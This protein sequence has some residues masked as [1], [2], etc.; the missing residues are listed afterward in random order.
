MTTFPVSHLHSCLGEPYF[1]SQLLPGEDVWVVSLVKDCLQLLEL[2]EGECRP[3][4]PLLPPQE[5]LVVHVR[6]VAEGGVCKQVRS[7]LLPTSYF[8]EW[9]NLH[10]WLELNGSSRE[11]N[12]T[13]PPGTSRGLG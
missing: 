1:A 4:P 3:V 7:V 11:G 2:L 12:L 5:G 8:C 13:D 9:G 6:G 10:G